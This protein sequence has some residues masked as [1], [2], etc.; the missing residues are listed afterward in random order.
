VSRS[1]A[2]AP[3][4]GPSCALATSTPLA[5][6]V[7]GDRQRDKFSAPKGTHHE[8]MEAAAASTMAITEPD[9]PGIKQP[10]R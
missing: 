9:L 7:T 8:V 5:R 4:T 2:P 1:A 10:A 6:P 3:P